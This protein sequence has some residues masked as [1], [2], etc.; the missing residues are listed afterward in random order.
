M[1][2][3]QEGTATG[4]GPR[5][6]MQRETRNRALILTQDLRQDAAAMARLLSSPETASDVDLKIVEE[7]WNDLTRTMENLRKTLSEAF[8]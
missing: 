2:T 4:E 1:A 7:T 3:S 6:V 8:E 5:P